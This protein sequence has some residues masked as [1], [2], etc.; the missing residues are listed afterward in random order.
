M[1]LVKEK[2]KAELL[3]NTM[4]GKGIFRGGI[5]DKNI[6]SKS[7]LGLQ[8]KLRNYGVNL[9]KNIDALFPKVDWQI[10]KNYVMFQKFLPN[11]KFDTRVTVIGNRAFAFRRLTRDDDFRASGSG[12][13]DFNQKDIDKNC[14]RL[15]LDVSK[16]CG[17]QSMAYDFLYNEEGNPEFCEISYSYADWAVRDAP[18]Y[19]DENLNFYEGHFW[20]NYTHLRTLLDMPELKQP[21]LKR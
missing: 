20:P 4:F 2:N 18:G 3:I 19:Y 16:K 5:P 14:I 1:L 7:R 9:V 10:D 17:F 8:K 13:I 12:K 15:A 11:N 21:E 6:V